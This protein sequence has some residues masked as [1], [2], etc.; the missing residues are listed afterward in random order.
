[1]C[2]VVWCNDC[3][4]LHSSIPTFI[5][6]TSIFGMM[7]KIEKNLNQKKKISLLHLDMDNVFQ[8]VKNIKI[9]SNQGK[10]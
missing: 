7:E 6:L 8:K 10:M 2:G 5:F 1:M 3:R 9:T 4:P